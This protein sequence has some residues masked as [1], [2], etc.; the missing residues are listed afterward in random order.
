MSTE[1]YLPQ[2][3][4]SLLG[5]N[6]TT[7]RENLS[8]RHQPAAQSRDVHS[9][10]APAYSVSPWC[11]S[12]SKRA[13]DLVCVIPA[14]IVISPLLAIVAFAVWLTSPGPV[15][16]RQQRAGRDRNLFTIYKFRTM[17]EDSELIGP[18]LTATGDPRIT[19]IGHFLRRFKLDELPQL[20]NVLRGEMSL[21]GPRPKLPDLEWTSVPC[22]PGITG[23]ATLLFRKEQ[24]I[25]REIPAGQIS[26]FYAQYIAPTKVRTDAE[27]MK[28]ATFQSDLHILRKTLAGGGYHATRENLVSPGPAIQPAIRAFH[29]SR[30]HSIPAQSRW[31][32]KNTRPRNMRPGTAALSISLVTYDTEPAV[33]AEALTSIADST[34][35]ANV[36]VVDNSA[37]PALGATAERFNAVYIHSGSNI[38]FGRAHN[39]ALKAIG[40]SSKYHVILNPDISFGPNVLDEL[41]G[42]M[43]INPEIGWVMPQV[44]YPDGSRQDLCKRLP[45]PWDLFRRRFLAAYGLDFFLAGQNRFL[46]GDLDLTRPRPVPYLSGCF[47]LVRTEVLQAVGGFDEQFFMYLEDTD[48]TR[49]I[50]ERALTVY[51]PYASVYHAHGRGSYRSA[52]LLGHHLLSTVQY[53]SKWGWFLDRERSRINRSAAFDDPEIAVPAK[54]GDWVMS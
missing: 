50:G 1:I 42:F 7:P 47:A 18:G 14:L 41:H 46:C 5:D 38:G 43:E 13:F 8:R 36:Y 32:E 27:Y 9:Q 10:S 12:A 26:D 28:S 21:V 33:L 23:A 44:L 52:R 20:F 30:R 15:I 17:V 39:L 29:K 6:R 54:L 53:F 3:Q 25:L 45:S 37:S 19:S 24:H 40:N 35:S 51:Y 49:R 34:L 2:I 11:A 4:E 16:F 48:L 31:K 22:R